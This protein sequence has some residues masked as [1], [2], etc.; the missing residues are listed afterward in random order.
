MDD[1]KHDVND[2]YEVLDPTNTK[3]P[4]NKYNWDS[5]YSV[6]NPASP[7]Y[8]ADLDRTRSLTFV[9]IFFIVVAQLVLPLIP[10]YLLIWYLCHRWDIKDDLVRNGTR[11]MGRFFLWMFFLS[12]A[13]FV[14][15]ILIAKYGIQL[16]EYES[17]F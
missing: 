14:G 8:D 5:P 3:S 11:G 17:N 12:I 16:G 1:K 6:I 15:K 13:L 10:G 2:V 4:F 7:H 9:G